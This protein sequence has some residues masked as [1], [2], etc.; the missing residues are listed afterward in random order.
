MGTPLT[1]SVAIRGC[2]SSQAATLEVGMTLSVTQ[3]FNLVGIAKIRWRALLSL[4]SLSRRNIL[5]ERVECCSL[6]Q[7]TR[8][9]ATRRV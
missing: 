4:Y 1:R 2:A 7:G 3:R 9:V 6:Y 8:K 5:H